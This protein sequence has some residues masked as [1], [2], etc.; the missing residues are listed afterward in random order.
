MDFTGLEDSPPRGERGSPDGD[1]AGRPFEK[2]FRSQVR[3]KL[4]I[5]VE[6]LKQRMEIQ[7]KW[8]QSYKDW[9]DKWG[10]MLAQAKVEVETAQNDLDAAEEELKGICAE[11][12]SAMEQDKALLFDPAALPEYEYIYKCKKAVR[13]ALVG[14][15]L[16][17]GH[18]CY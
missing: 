6:A 3:Q 13:L 7:Y 10:V 1:V 15:K 11:R 17:G 4:Q 12:E 2:N 5:L 16:G 9:S 8:L 14:I 18:V